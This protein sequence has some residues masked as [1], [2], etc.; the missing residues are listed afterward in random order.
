MRPRYSVVLSCPPRPNLPVSGSVCEEEE[1]GEKEGGSLLSDA[2]L[3]R[4]LCAFCKQ[5]AEKLDAVRQAAGD[6]LARLLQ[7]LAA[8][9]QS[10]PASSSSSTVVV[11]VAAIQETLRDTQ[12]ALFPDAAALSASD[13]A[14]V[15]LNWSK[16]DHVFPFAARLLSRQ[17]RVRAFEEEAAAA[18]GGLS[19]SQ[20]LFSAVLSGLVISIGGLTET[21]AREALRALA[22]QCKSKGKGPQ[23]GDSSAA[24]ASARFVRQLGSGLLDILRSNSRDDRVV[25]PTIKAVEKLLRAGVFDMPES[26]CDAGDSFAASLGQVLKAELAGCRSVGKLL[27][28]ADLTALLLAF[29]GPGR[30]QVRRQALRDLLTL[31]AHKYPVVRKCTQRRSCVL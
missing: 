24:S 2:V 17:V 28:Y 4:L 10:P 29:R 26:G 14:E 8:L 19:F 27:A 21:T 25:L 12:A 6:S 9:T 22:D 30:G 7:P 31:L 1:E 13:G 23:A 5:L 11:M 20:L 15:L 3:A 16:P 18:A